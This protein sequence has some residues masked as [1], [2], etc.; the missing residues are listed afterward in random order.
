M[1][2]SFAD[3][4]SIGVNYGRIANN[5]PSAAKVVR[6]VKSQGLER[7]KVYDTDAAVLKALS[8]SGIKVTFDLPN[9][10]LY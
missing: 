7:I 10:L 3:A 6:L 2:C 5:L 4:G 9:E 1:W 8:G